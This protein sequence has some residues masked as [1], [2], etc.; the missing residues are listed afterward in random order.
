MTIRA[1]FFL[2]AASIAAAQSSTISNMP[3]ATTLAGTE[4]F[5]LVQGGANK[6]GTISQV[7]TYT[8][9]QAAGTFAP[10]NNPTFTGSAGTI[11]S[12]WTIGGYLTSAS[13][14]S[15]Y[16]S[17]TTAASTYQPLQT[18]LTNFAALAD[19]AGLFTSDGAGG[20]SWT[21]KTIGGNGAGDSG[22]VVMF[23][24]NG[25]LI[26]QTYVRC[27]NGTNYTGI[28]SNGLSGFKSSQFCSLNWPSSP[29]SARAATLPDAS[30]TIY[31]VGQ[32]L[33]T[34]SSGTLTSATGLPISTGLTGAGTGV[35]TALGVNTGSAGAFVVLGGAGGT[36]SSLTLTNATGLPLAGVGGIDA[37]VATWMATPSE[38][39]MKL[40]TGGSGIGW[41]D[42]AQTWALAQT[43]SGLVSA[44][45][46]RP[47]A[48]Q[49]GSIGANGTAFQDGWF[50]GQV[51][52]QYIQFTGGSSQIW[53]RAAN[54]TG[55]GSAS[56][57]PATQ[58]FGGAEATGSNINGGNLNLGTR[59]TGTGTSGAVNL[60]AAAA[61]S[62]G[63]SLNALVTQ[64]SVTA[65]ATTIINPVAINFTSQGTTSGNGLTIQ[66]TTAATVGAQVEQSPYFIMTGAGWKTAATAASQPVSFLHNVVPVAGTA[67]PTGYWQVQAM[68][69][70]SGILPVMTLTSDPSTVG[71]TFSAG[72]LGIYR[73]RAINRYELT[74]DNG[75]TYQCGIGS[76]FQN[77][78]ALTRD[79]FIKWSS[80]TDANAGSKTL[81]LGR[82]AAFTAGV[83]QLGLDDP[84][85]PTSQTITA[86][87]VTTGTG[88]NLVLKGGS[89]S[90]N[91]GVVRIRG[92]TANDTPTA[93]DVGESTTSLVA[94]GSAVSLTTATGANVTS[95]TLTAGD[96]DVSGIVNVAFTSA[97]HTGTTASFSTT[98]ATPATDG[99]EGY[100]G[101][102]L[103]I[104]SA[105]TSIP[106]TEGRLSLSTSTTVYLT[107]KSTFSAGTAAAFGKITARRRR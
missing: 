37:A 48:N 96:W 74:T 11:P 95:I 98:T 86:H 8:L 20:Y 41:L 63:S 50:A 13:A 17:Q 45:N 30:G 51:Q 21:A 58:T 89:G 22:K 32:P 73:V 76:D 55:L 19:A 4:P 40:V 72:R 34:P 93:G 47:V 107:V 83:L 3:A 52:V 92:S 36:P 25:S 70:N 35:L 46:V 65:A 49:G 85:T 62:S 75:T 31:I 10:I 33:G 57:T 56:G 81:V 87:S 42:T 91:N 9:G 15:T 24:T 105:T 66:S 5:P 28:V 106:V 64:V 39:N 2:A 79:W 60:Q 69:N 27:T 68:V 29:T 43:F 1:L 90:V 97:T 99:T 12:G 80:T 7:S 59:G 100:T 101:L 44:N 102:Q 6:K 67:A 61:G 23:D 16:L 82:D 78:I 94:S 14:A 71:P 103:T 38:A 104:T 26:A 18:K 53:G 54:N 88:A 84:T 77:A